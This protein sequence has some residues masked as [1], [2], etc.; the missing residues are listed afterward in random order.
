MDPASPS[1]P[2]TLRAIAQRLGISHASVSKA[3]RN[4]PKIKE[5]TRARVQKMARE[6]GYRPNP[7]ATGLAE[8]KRTS[9]I[10]PIQAVLA[11]FNFWPR[12]QQLREYKAFNLYWRGAQSAAEKFGYRLEEFTVNDGVSP[13]RLQNI[14]LT[15]NIHGILI[16][17]LHQT[18][19]NWLDFEWSYFSVVRLSRATMGLPDFPLVTSAQFDSGVMALKKM[20]EHGYERIGFFGHLTTRWT[21]LGGFLQEQMISIPK[22]QQ[23]PPM[24]LEETITD[25]V[26]KGSKAADEVQARFEKWLEK[27]QP[28]AI[29]TDSHVLALLLE[30][31]RRR[32]PEDVAV[33]ALNTLDT[34]FSAGLYQNPEEI[35]RVAVLVLISLIN[36]NAHGLPEIYREILV[37]GTWEDGNSLPLR[38]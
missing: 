20:L 26:L 27:D 15:R 28:D 2:V 6:M 7:M 1:P 12:P 34:P 9:T 3:L 36:D 14:L 37:K 18:M 32:V 21:Y 38:K 19:V 24:L 13:A 25:Q 29:L 5:T 31:A 16:A 35:G 4:D 33:A 23:I 10:R 22:S 17:P 8:Y 11:W 30:R